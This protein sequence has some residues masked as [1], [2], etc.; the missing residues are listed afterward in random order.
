[1]S[2]LLQQ[3]LGFCLPK[4]LL[5][6]NMTV[7]NSLIY[8]EES[9][10]LCKELAGFYKK[11]Q[12]YELEYAKVCVPFSHA[13]LD[14]REDLIKSNVLKSSLWSGFSEQIDQ[15]STLAR[16]HVRQTDAKEC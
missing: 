14:K 3:S 8:L 2:L 7:E 6:T 5:Q 1:M 9:V 4:S 11:R 15:T 12:A 13:Q 10:K 16:A